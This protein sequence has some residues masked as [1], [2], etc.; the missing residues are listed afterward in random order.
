MTYKGRSGYRLKKGKSGD[1]RWHKDSEFGAALDKHLKTAGAT[2]PGHARA[3]KMFPGMKQASFSRSSLDMRLSSTP[4]KFYGDSIII[5][6]DRMMSEW[7][8]PD[9]MHHGT[10][11]NFDK[12]AESPFDREFGSQTAHWNNALGNHFTPSM[13][14][15]RKFSTARQSDDEWELVEDEKSRIIP[16]RLA[17]KNPLVANSERYLDELAGFYSLS[18]LNDSEKHEMMTGRGG[19]EYRELFKILD[20][21]KLDFVDKMRETELL[22]DSLS[23][24]DSRG[25]RQQHSFRTD[26]SRMMSNFDGYYSRKSDKFKKGVRERIR[27]EDKQAP[28]SYGQQRQLE[29]GMQFRDMLRTI[30]FD[31]VIYKNNREGS[32]GV[33]PLSNAAIQY[34]NRHMAPSVTELMTERLAKGKHLQEHK[35]L[36][37][38]LIAISKDD[39][40]V[41]HTDYS[42]PIA[43]K[44]AVVR[45]VA[46][47]SDYDVNTAKLMI[48]MRVK[49]DP[50]KKELL[51]EKVKYRR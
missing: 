16:V 35:D 38:E 26:L 7:R 45:N 51:F 24:L 20:N 17:I 5:P 12:F 39:Q 40:G 48:E 29:L 25:W 4:A 49:S 23:G 2:S 37:D 13:A 22:S 14:V 9:V 30:G 47:A 28:P 42:H 46:L 1:M 11:S 27:G 43:K 36:N 32:I 8:A 15:A 41:P 21:D 31:G 33:A 50:S 34:V 18:Q 10:R 19:D 6:T 44:A 3:L